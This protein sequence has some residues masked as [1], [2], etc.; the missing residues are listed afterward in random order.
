MGQVAICMTMAKYTKEC[1][2][3]VKRIIL[4]QR[5]FQMESSI[6]VNMS[7]ASGKAE[8]YLNAKMDLSYSMD[9]LLMENQAELEDS[10]ILGIVEH[11]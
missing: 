11:G 10:T 9:S 6:K 4:E 1:S 5:S 3:K 2:R 7:M 8:E